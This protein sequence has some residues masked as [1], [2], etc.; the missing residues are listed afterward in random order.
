[1]DEATIAL[2]V[3]TGAVG[4]VFLGFLIWGIKSGQFHNVEEAKY[5]VFR[6][7]KNKNKDV[8]NQGDSPTKEVKHDA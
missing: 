8:E 7:Q 6:K 1:M 3:M 2:T 5:Q 4:I